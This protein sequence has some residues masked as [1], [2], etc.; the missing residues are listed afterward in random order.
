[1]FTLVSQE[2]IRS[3]ILEVFTCDVDENEALKLLTSMGM[4]WNVKRALRENV[5]NVVI[6]KGI[7]IIKELFK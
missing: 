3:H 2:I 4:L 7:Q 1:M 6:D 5:K